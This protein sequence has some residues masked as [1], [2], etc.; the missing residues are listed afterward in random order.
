MRAREFIKES[1]GMNAPGPD[2]GPAVSNY[3]RGYQTPDQMYQSGARFSKQVTDFNMDPMDGSKMMHVDRIDQ[4][5]DGGMTER[6]AI[7]SYANQIAVTPKELTSLYKG[8]KSRLN[9][10]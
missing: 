10:T 4:R 9:I 2:S 8:Y 5:I 1:P 3:P 7:E 6:E